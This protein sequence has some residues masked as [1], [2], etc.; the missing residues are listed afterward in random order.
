MSPIS[1]LNVGAVESLL[2]SGIDSNIKAKLMKR[3]QIQI[4][5]LLLNAKKRDSTSPEFAARIA[6]LET[7][8]NRLFPVD[9]KGEP[10]TDSEEGQTDY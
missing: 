8:M 9:S 5:T 7:R 6:S 1:I 3:I 2:L 10:D 4:P